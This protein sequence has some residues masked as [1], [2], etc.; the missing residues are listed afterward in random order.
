VSEQF[1]FITLVPPPRI[2]ESRYDAQAF[3]NAALVLAG[4]AL[5]VRVTRDRGQLLVEL[6]PED[7][8]D[9]FDEQIVLQFVGAEAEARS[10]IEGEFRV[11][12]PSARAMR[13]HFPQILSAFQ[14]SE[15][16]RTKA[17]LTELQLQRARRLF[18]WNG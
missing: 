8:Y 15:W 13:R 6:S 2:L 4:D 11:L 18:G 9:W 10:L 7:H 12:A 16:P 3:G 5:R 17:A 14:P 1:A